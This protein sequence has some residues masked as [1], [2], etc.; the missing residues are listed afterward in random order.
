MAKTS[1][2]NDM[3]GSIS[4]DTQ[5]ADGYILIDFDT[6]LINRDD[7]RPIDHDAVKDLA[8]SIEQDGLAQPILVRTIDEQVDVFELIAGQHRCEAYRL[9]KAKYPSDPRWQKIECKVVKGMDDDRA[10]RLM[11]ATNIMDANHSLAERGQMFLELYGEKAEEIQAEQGGRKREIIQELYT[12]DTGNVIAPTSV[13]NAIK[14]AEAEASLDS[15]LFIDEWGEAFGKENCRISSVIKQSLSRLDEGVQRQIYNDWCDSGSNSRWLQEEV[16]LYSGRKKKVLSKAHTQ[17]VDGVG[18]L[19]R[20]QRFDDDGTNHEVDEM[21]AEVVS[22]L[23]G[24]L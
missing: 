22:S 19:A 7:N 18:L 1:A 14:A 8:A 13:E 6:Q 9:L 17:I 12:A 21:I 23:R 20:C 24:M 2:V 16:D 4:V 3:L 5:K 15:S 10:E 11:Y